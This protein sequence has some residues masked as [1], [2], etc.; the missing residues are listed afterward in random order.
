M[1]LIASFALSLEALWTA[2][3]K[4]ATY[5]CDVN[6]RVSCSTV[7][8]SWQSTLIHL[9]KYPV[10]NAFIG[11]AAFSVLLTIGV[12]LMICSTPEWFD[13]CLSMGCLLAFAAARWLFLQS[14]TVIRAFCPWC[15]LMWT[16]VTIA[17]SAEVNSFLYHRTNGL[18][19]KYAGSL[20]SL[21]PVLTML[22]SALAIVL[23]EAL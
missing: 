18:I 17:A 5:V 9:G 11:L 15:I 10:P 19:H 23:I 22:F 16:G 1:G 3:H 21:I 8:R 2:G 6:T 13:A 20:F 12:I 14:A 4:N 7:A